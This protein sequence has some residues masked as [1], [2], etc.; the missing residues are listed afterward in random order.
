MRPSQKLGASDD[1][2][3]LMCLSQHVYQ[4][5]LDREPDRALREEDVLHAFLRPVLALNRP[6]SECPLGLVCEL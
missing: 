6:D 4:L 1:P 5:V 2:D 3:D